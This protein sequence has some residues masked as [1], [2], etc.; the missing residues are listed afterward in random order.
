MPLSVVPARPEIPP[1]PVA[2]A[3]V[4]TLTTSTPTTAFEGDCP[5]PSG[6]GTWLHVIVGA[7][8][9]MLFS[10]GPCGH[11]RGILLSLAPAGRLALASH[12]G[13]G[14][15]GGGATSP[16]I[17]ARGDAGVMV[18]R[19]VVLIDGLAGVHPLWCQ[20]R[21]GIGTLRQGD[22]DPRRERACNQDM[23]EWQDPDG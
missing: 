10:T 4:C 19:C 11:V 16:A 3:P 2:G 20:P 9:V 17:T 13:D 14:G 5:S 15:E 18:G 22:S 7:M 8:M 1:L 21:S 23:G 12:R 6:A